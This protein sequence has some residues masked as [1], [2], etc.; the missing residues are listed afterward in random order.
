MTIH[1]LIQPVLEVVTDDDGKDT[2]STTTDT[3][4]RDEAEAL[5]RIEAQGWD[6]HIT[7]V[8]QTSDPHAAVIELTS[9]DHATCGTCGQSV[10]RHGAV[11]W[12]DARTGDVQGGWSHQHGC[13]AWN[14]PISVM[15]R[16]DLT[17][18]TDVAAEVPALAARLAAELAD[19]YAASQAASLDA[20]TAG[21]RRDLADAIALRDSG[22]D[23]ADY[24]TGSDTEPGVWVNYGGELEAW[25]Y[26]DGGDGETVAVAESDLAR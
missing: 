13:G 3:T 19:T 7:W 16:L 25:A 23:E 2:M 8:G 12:I 15:G 11:D 10:H 6:L 20:S 22:A 21:L 24:L 1:H 17:D 26:I 18:D 14:A 4:T 5:A 9:N